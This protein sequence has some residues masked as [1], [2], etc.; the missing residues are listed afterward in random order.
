[1]VTP[2]GGGGGE[3]QCPQ[4]QSFAFADRSRGLAVND[5][6]L[7]QSR[8]G[9]MPAPA[10]TTA[11][12]GISWRR[13][14]LPPGGVADTTLTAA[15][16]RVYVI[17]A[18]GTYDSPVCEQ[19]AVSRDR[20]RSWSVQSLRVRCFGA[21][22]FEQ[23][24]WLTCGDGDG[25]PAKPTTIVYVSDDSGQTWRAITGGGLFNPSQIVAIGPN[26]AIASST[27]PIE[28]PSAGLQLWETSDG[29]ERWARYWPA[30]PLGPGN[31][32]TPWAYGRVADRQACLRARPV[33]ISLHR[34]VVAAADAAD[35]T[36]RT[37]RYLRG[38]WSWVV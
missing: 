4:R 1:V 33:G 11:D 9:A 14:R 23:Q 28:G 8:G 17:V 7:C 6:A 18:D 15:S 36:R 27:N 12:G 30:L 24:I 35:N 20:G 16:D 19:I 37:S 3:I 29:S 13:I 25:H 2:N 34:S 22:A 21:A 32:P 10:F 31:A 5:G 26:H 38:I